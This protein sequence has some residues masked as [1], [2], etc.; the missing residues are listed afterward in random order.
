MSMVPKQIHY[1]WFGDAPLGELE[2][3]CIDSW[4]SF[5]PDYQIVRWDESNFEINQCAYVREAYEKKKWAFVSDYARI[6]ILYQL[7]GLYF[8]TDVEIIRPMN[9]IVEHP[10]MGFEV[11]PDTISM[12]SGAVNLGLGFGVYPKMDILKEILES[13]ENDRFVLDD[14]TLNYKTIVERVTQVLKMHGLACK[15]GIQNVDGV[16]IFPA[17][18]F[19]PV[20]SMTGEENITEQTRSIHHFTASWQSKMMREVGK[21]KQE[22]RANHGIGS[23]IIVS[24]LSRLIY[25]AN[26]GD[27]NVLKRRI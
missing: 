11:D 1:C 13:Y 21:I 18:Y 14:N 7:G 16:N 2:Q 10:F 27:F 5:F 3:R 6:A 20:D 4:K 19:N 8:D 9:D 12:N 26:T 24:L 17:T 25:F 23:D 15:N 22:L